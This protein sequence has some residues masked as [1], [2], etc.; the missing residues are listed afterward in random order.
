MAHDDSNGSAVDH[1]AE[2]SRSRWRTATRRPRK[3]PPGAAKPRQDRRLLLEAL[4]PRILLSADLDLLGTTALTSSLG[5]PAPDVDLSASNDASDYDAALSAASEIFAQD[6]GSAPV[7]SGTLE[8]PGETD[9]YAFTLTEAKQIVFDSLTQRSDIRWSLTGPFGSEVAGRRFDQSDSNTLG[10]STILSLGA[11]DYILSVDGDSAATG[12]YAFRLLDLAQAT[13]VEYGQAVTGTLTEADFTDGYSFEVTAGDALFFQR[14]LL[15]GATGGGGPNW[16]VIGPAG[17]LIF[18]A[19]FDDRDVA[20]FTQGGTY[21][22]LVE[23]HIANAGGGLNYGFTIHRSST[24]TTPLTLGQTTVGA[25]EA[26]GRQD[27]YTFTLAAPARLYFDSLVPDSGK[28]WSLAGPRGVEVSGRRLDQSDAVNVGGNPV[29]DLVAGSYT[30]TVDGSGANTGR[31]AFRLLDLASAT[32]IA[33]GAAQGGTLSDAGAAGAL[34]RTVSTAPVTYPEGSTN[35]ALQSIGTSNYVAVPDAATLKPA[36]ITLEAWVRRDPNAPNNAGV[37]MK[38]STS[39]WND[40]YG[41]YYSNDGFINFFVNHWSN[42]RVRVELPADEWAHVAGTYDGANLRLYL[43]GVLAQTVAYTQPINHSSAELRIGSGAGGEYPWRGAIDEVRLWT[44]AR[45]AAAISANMGQPLAS[46][47]AALSGYWRF[48]E[49]SGAAVADASIR[50]N[51]GTVVGFGRETRMYRFDLA[52]GDQILLDDTLGGSGVYWRLI[53]PSGQMLVGQGFSDATRNITL[54]G[55]YTLLVEGNVSNGFGT[56]FGFTVVNQGNTPIP[57]FTGEALTLG[58]RVDAT[59]GVAGEVDSYVFTTSGPTRLWFDS[60]TNNGNVRVALEGPRGTEFTNH[61]M[62]SGDL[63]LDLPLGGSYRLSVTSVNSAT[64]A[65]AFRLLD[66]SDATLITYDTE[67]IHPATPNNGARIYA[68]DGTAGDRIFF[69]ATQNNTWWTDWRLYD[70]WGR[71]VFWT[72][73]QDNNVTLAHTGRYTLVMDGEIHVAGTGTEFRFRLDTIQDGTAPLVLGAT[74]TGTIAGPGEVANHTFTL[75][76]RTSLYFDSHRNDGNLRWTLTGPGGTLISARQFSSADLPFTLDAGAYTLTVHRDGDGTGDYAFRL[77][78]IADAPAITLGDRVEVTNTPA[79]G[80]SLYRF[81]AN[82]GD[83]VFLN[84]LRNNIWWADWRLIDPRG[85]QI[86]QWD[87]QDID[88]VTL[89]LGGTWTV[90]I[91]TEVHIAGASSSFAFS[92][93]KVVDGQQAIALNATSVSGPLATDGRVG[94]ATL[95]TGKETAVVAHGTNTDL[96]NDVTIEFWL[97]Y[98]RAA[99]QWQP[100]LNKSNDTAANG[101]NR[102]YSMW[103]NDQ[104]YIH[105]TTAD[106][107]GQQELNSAPGSIPR[108]EWVHVAGVIDRTTGQMRLLLNGVEVGNRTIRTTQAVTHTDPLRIAGAVEPFGWPGFEG[109]MDEFRLWNVARTNGQISGAMN[110]ALAGNEAGLQLYLP[111]NAADN[112]ASLP[113]AGPAAT[114]AAILDRHEGVAGLITGRIDVPGAVDRYTFTLAQDTWLLFDTVTDNDQVG[115]TVTGPGGLGFSRNLRN[116]DDHEFGSGNPLYFARAGSYTITVDA[117]GDQTHAYA[118][119]LLDIAQGTTVSYGDVVTGSL[120][121]V[122]STAV[123]RFDAAANDRLYLDVQ[124]WSKGTDRGLWRMFDPSGRQIAYSNLT[125]LDVMT[126]SLAGT[127]TLVLEGR[128]WDGGPA[129]YQFLL[130][131]VQDDVTASTLGTNPAPGPYWTTE[132][133]LG[134]GLQFTGADALSVS[135]AQLDLTGNLTMEAWVRP[136]FYADQWTPLFYKGDGPT[137]ARGYSLWL[138]NDGLVYLGTRDAQGEQSVQTAVGQVPPGAW[139]H[140]AGVIDRSSGQLRIVIN[141]VE[142]ATAGVRGGQAISVPDPLLIGRTTE[143]S[144]AYELFVGRLDEVRVW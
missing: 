119:R 123:F 49:A 35:R 71:Q 6:T 26:P 83:R 113:D 97:R 124:S 102:T 92:I 34:M 66:M 82:A 104:G 136:D 127:Y 84:A 77:H 31:Y 144:T 111:M 138:R 44:V 27:A 91:D 4:E 141:G 12:N 7:V 58:A 23:G 36:E 128:V 85:R 67:V 129:N 120:T 18:N 108:G 112:A 38:S 60:L 116:G 103:L 140:V 121:P 76:D 51:H 15:T 57:G 62:S 55:T 5:T 131:K 118:F 50:G 56:P 133:R 81:E 13:S 59:L 110:A 89:E 93:N 114:N 109:A 22:L 14:T 64:G 126:L 130:Q 122:N 61:P 90:V 96:R 132:G 42:S 52:R 117:A 78:A 125:D 88:P 74:T 79:N 11:G 137:A 1:R 100:L 53:D 21:T 134:G 73:F 95:F 29:L 70:P 41:L 69:N 142:V 80:A 86:G 87:F 135:S 143:T 75:D 65:Y 25:I 40:G 46:F 9:R 39:S 28:T 99:A 8:V 101:S 106:A 105:F 94:G 47:P 10:G 20:T 19:A 107:S 98:D 32:G 139:T 45:G 37:A 48:D 68:F 24:D 115:V 17:Q 2:R 30:L 54:A 63:V 72:D 33:T 3:A 16:R 43:D